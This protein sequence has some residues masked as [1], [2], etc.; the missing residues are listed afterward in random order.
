MKTKYT[1]PLVMRL[2]ASLTLSL[3]L[4]MTVS[5]GMQKEPWLSFDKKES[6]STFQSLERKYDD[7]RAQVSGG[8]THAEK[9]EEAAA[10]WQAVAAIFIVG[11]GFALIYGAALGSQ[12]R[13]V[14][15]KRKRTAAAARPEETPNADFTD[16]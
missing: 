16:V 4:T 7:L 11:A 10:L 15:A 14:Q 2:L 6:R 5:C 3:L 9:A 13:R 1:H 12:A 8:K